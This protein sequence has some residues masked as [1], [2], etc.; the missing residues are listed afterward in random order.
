MKDFDVRQLY[1]NGDLRDRTTAAKTGRL[2]FLIRKAGS[3]WETIFKEINYLRFMQSNACHHNSQKFASPG[4]ICAFCMTHYRSNVNQRKTESVLL[5]TRRKK[6][7]FL[8]SILPAMCQLLLCWS[9]L[10]MSESLGDFTCLG[11][12]ELTF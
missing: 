3:S 2:T 1:S 5:A 6:A 7:S 11:E 12:E 9:N 4:E 8:L 10:E